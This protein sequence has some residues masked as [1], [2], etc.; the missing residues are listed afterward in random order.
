MDFGSSCKLSSTHDTLQRISYSFHKKLIYHIRKGLNHCPLNW[1][2]WYLDCWHNW[3]CILLYIIIEYNRLIVTSEFPLE[4]DQVHIPVYAKE[5]SLLQFFAHLKFLK[6]ANAECIAAASWLS[7]VYILIKKIDHCIR[8]SL[9]NGRWSSFLATSSSRV[10]I[11]NDNVCV[12]FKSHY[13]AG[14][15]IWC[16]WFG[17]FVNFIREKCYQ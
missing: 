2:P 3:I 14:L 17:V 1:Y 4:A 10:P 9:I 16:R 13:S 11:K 7:L 8:C 5:H 12:C 6:A 15:W